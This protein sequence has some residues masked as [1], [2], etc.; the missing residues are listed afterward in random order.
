MQI[1]PEWGETSATV[2]HRRGV[3]MA[4]VW[5]WATSHLSCSGRREQGGSVHICRCLS[6][7]HICH[8]HL[9]VIICR[10]PSSAS[11]HLPCTSAIHICRCNLPVHI[12]H[13]H[14]PYTFGSSSFPFLFCSEPQLL[15]L[16]FRGGGLLPLCTLSASSQTGTE[17]YLPGHS[18]SQ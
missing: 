18:N 6:A 15:P 16:I 4:G 1:I 11:A 2:H 7:M 12:C 14:L 10:C 9:P 17:V 5:T 8:A 13:A 3:W